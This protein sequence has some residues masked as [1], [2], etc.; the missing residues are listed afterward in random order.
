VTFRSDLGQSAVDG[1][2]D[3]G[4]EAGVVTGQTVQPWRCR[5]LAQPLQG[6]HGGDLFSEFW[7]CAGYH[8]GVGRPG[9]QDVDADTA[10][11]QFGGQVRAKE[12]RAAWWRRRRFDR[13]CLPH[14]A[15]PL[16]MIDPPLLIS[17]SSF[18]T[19]NSAPRTL[20][21]N[22]VSK[23]SSVT[24]VR[25]LR[26]CHPCADVEDIDAAVS[27][28]Y[29]VDEEVEIA[30]ITRVAAYTGGI[31]ANFADCVV[32]LVFAAAGDVD[33]SAFGDEEFGCGQRPCL[34][35]LR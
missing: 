14:T 34:R 22:T 25:A 26:R 24:A 3:A 33:V 17:E 12:R 5:R 19:V 9:A 27:G 18:C 10:L 21:P 7:W 29:R 31:A 11:C 2:V 20:T 6:D 32:E 8:G 30:R 13:E 16:R 1:Q 35:W 23:E 15:D 4:N 28:T